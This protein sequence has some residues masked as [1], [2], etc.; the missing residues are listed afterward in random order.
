MNQGFSNCH[1]YDGQYGLD[2]WN[3]CVVG[4]RVTA[5]IKMAFEWHALTPAECGLPRR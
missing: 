4:V 2:N 5:T 3:S 1:P